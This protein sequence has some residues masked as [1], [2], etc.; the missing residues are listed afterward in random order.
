MIIAGMQKNSFVDYPGRISA[1]LF[2][3]GCNMDCF[4][5]HNRTLL[6]SS[7]NHEMYSCETVLK[8]LKER[9]KFLDG[10]VI[11]G[12][13]PTLQRGLE[14]FIRE[15]KELGYPV[16]LDTNGTSPHV[17]E[18]LVEKGL[19][20]YVA[21]DVKA[22]IK[23]YSEICGVPVDIKAIEASIHLLLQGKIAYEFRTTVAPQLREEDILDIAMMIK[24]ARL[25]VLQRLR[26]KG[27]EP[28]SFPAGLVPHTSQSLQY[29]AE[30]V[31]EIVACC[32]TRGNT[33]MAS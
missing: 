27:L 10:L 33:S 28:G 14:S 23:R 26:E 18:S 7:S 25:Y 15:V 9:K 30:R 19:L 6:D 13:E 22:P 21:M 5:C 31:R 24:G 1:V 2:T 11:S 16:K 29:M 4:Y 3:P 20:D 17:L 8:F 32:E 12:G